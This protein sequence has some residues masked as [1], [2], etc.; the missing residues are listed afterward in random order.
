MGSKLPSDK[1]LIDSKI[2]TKN[3]KPSSLYSL[4]S[5]FVAQREYKRL[6]RH[7]IFS[8]AGLFFLVP[9]SF[10]A[11][12]TTWLVRA[13]LEVIES[14]LSRKEIPETATLFPS[15]W[16][17]LSTSVWRVAPDD[18]VGLRRYL[19]QPQFNELYSYSSEQYS[20]TSKTRILDET[21]RAF[22]RLRT[23]L[24]PQGDSIR[25]PRYLF[26][27]ISGFKENIM[28]GEDWISISIDNYLGSTNRFYKK[29][30]KGVDKNYA[31]PEHIPYDA[32]RMWLR[33]EYPM[34]QDKL[35]ILQDRIDYYVFQV[36]LLVKAFPNASIEDLLSWS[37]EDRKV[38]KKY[39]EEWLS[40]VNTPYALQTTSLD[41]A[42][43]LLTDD[44]ILMLDDADLPRNLAY[45]LAWQIYLDRQSQQD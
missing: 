14:L 40:I 22:D 26:T 34:S 7:R 45:W 37:K 31:D 32:L 42:Q 21:G 30:Q 19:S 12:N 20:S 4:I 41:I 13:D 28:V 18:L 16:K 36:L 25:L 17:V 24:T 9:L 44:A 2:R 39:G 5:R 29:Y 10:Q 1:N 15:Y 33:T 8:L 38:A 11:Q 23:E 43:A 35:L 6:L 3:G 27:H